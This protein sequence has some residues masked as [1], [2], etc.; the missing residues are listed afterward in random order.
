[1][2]RYA[3]EVLDQKCVSKVGHQMI[4]FLGELSVLPNQMDAVDV[5]QES[6]P[7]QSDIV[8]TRGTM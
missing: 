4:E 6:P 5:R 3:R 1:M 8:G 2:A 7:R